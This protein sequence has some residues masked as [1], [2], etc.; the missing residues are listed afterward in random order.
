MPTYETSNVQQS[1]A[2]L[3]VPFVDEFDGF[4][5]MILSESDEFPDELIR[6]DDGTFTVLSFNIHYEESD[7][8]NFVVY[9][10]HFQEEPDWMNW[11]LSDEFSDDAVVRVYKIHKSNIELHNIEEG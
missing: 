7:Y 8:V 9:H 2:E 4:P 11:Q 6:N 10:H 3:G 1:K 5:T